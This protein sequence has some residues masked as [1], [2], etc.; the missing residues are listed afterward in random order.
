VSRSRSVA[1]A[2][3]GLTGVAWAGL[4]GWERLAAGLVVA[5]LT[6]AWTWTR[7]ARVDLS[8][9]AGGLALLVAP[10]PTTALPI[11]LVL[12]LALASRTLDD[13]RVFVLGAAG[14]V[15]PA[16][17]GWWI[18][19]VAAGL[20]WSTTTGPARGLALPVAGLALLGD[21]GFVA[22]L[23]GAAAV[24]A[25]AQLARAIATGRAN[26]RN[27][28]I[29]ADASLLAAPGPGLVALLAAS[30]I[31]VGSF[32]AALR[33]AGTSLA[34]GTVLGLAHVGAAGLVRSTD[35][36]IETLT[37]TWAPLAAAITVGALGDLVGVLSI[38]AAGLTLAAPAA[39]VGLGIVT[40]TAGA[41]QRPAPA[42][43]PGTA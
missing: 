5:A 15:L 4:Q 19:L 8:L 23:A 10:E 30:V 43:E 9:A 13:G 22:G 18:P 14:A 17:A 42:S 16:P 26:A 1:I 6:A 21:P 24:L 25:A 27:A 36:A 12:G 11:G 40:A 20:V 39:A 2:V 37:G 7:L 33:W 32:P 29:V 3:L 35:S 38:A 34:A 31:D 41:G 28:R